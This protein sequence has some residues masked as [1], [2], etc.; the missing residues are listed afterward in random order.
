[1]LRAG[2]DSLR[3]ASVAQDDKPFWVAQDDRFKRVIES[4]SRSPSMLLR[5]GSDSLRCASVAQDDKPFWVAQD[6]R[7][8]RV[9]KATAG[10]STPFAALRSLRMTSH[11]GLL[12]M[13]ARAGRPVVHGIPP[14]AESAKDGAPGISGSADRP[15]HSGWSKLQPCHP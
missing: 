4:N 2:S 14:F 7:F 6:D 8:K 3:C 10:P 15:E 12:G 11:Y 9:S 13:T 5:A 1:L